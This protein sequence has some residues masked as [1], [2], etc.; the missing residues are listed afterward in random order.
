LIIIPSLLDERTILKGMKWQYYCKDLRRPNGLRILSN[1][2][3][4]NYAYHTGLTALYSIIICTVWILLFC[5]GSKSGARISTILSIIL[6]IYC[7][8]KSTVD[9]RGGADKSLAKPGRK[10]ATLTKLGIYSTYSPRSSIHFLGPC[11]NFCKPLKTNSEGC[12][13]NQVSTAAVTSALDQKWRPF[14]YFFSP[15]NRW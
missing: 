13:S 5:S 4:C 3:F 11:A 14:N 10:Q 12:P 6:L 15:G 2:I 9:I 7:R 1:G 8:F